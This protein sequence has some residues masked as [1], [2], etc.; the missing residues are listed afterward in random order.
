MGNKNE[1]DTLDKKIAF[2][3]DRYSKVRQKELSL[4]FKYEDQF[5][6]KLF[7]LLSGLE[8]W[9]KDMFTWSV[10][11]GDF[12]QMSVAK[13]LKATGVRAGVSDLCC[14][15]GGRMM[16]VE[17]KRPGGRLSDAQIRFR[18]KCEANN[19]KFVEIGRAHV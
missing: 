4:K 5:Q 14:M 8:M 12:R 18:G 7:Y 1:C 11:N 17:N 10:P 3:L 16:Y 13:R 6:S 2:L 19:F 15:G 9:Y